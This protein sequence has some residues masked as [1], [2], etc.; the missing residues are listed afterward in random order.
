[1]HDNSKYTAVLCA[2]LGLSACEQAS[3]RTGAGRG[4]S[5]V[6]PSTESVKDFGV[7]VV[8]FNAVTTDQLTPDIAQSYGIVRSQDRAMLNISVQRKN[9]GGL[10]TAVSAGVAASAVN[11]TGQTRN[12]AVRE[13]RE[14]EA[15][16]YIGETVIADGETLIFTVNVTPEGEANPLTVRFQK[17]F[18]V[19]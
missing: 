19:D 13:I 15:V 11:L 9:E 18:F 1:M 10:G 7:Y 6:M 2:L 12:I 8:H 17:Q 4:D 14:E 3:D 16:Y 5:T